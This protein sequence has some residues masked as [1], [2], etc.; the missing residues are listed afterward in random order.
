MTVYRVP[1]PARRLLLLP[2]LIL[3][4]MLAMTYLVWDH[5]RQSARQE[6]RAQF[7]FAL[8]DAVSRIAQRIAAYEQM[9][10]GVQGL[11]ATTELHN[12]QA[13][14]DYVE[15]LQLAA[16][17]SG[18]QLLGVVERVDPSARAA[19]VAAIRRLGVADYSI[20]PPGEREVYAPI[21]QRES[22][23]G[24]N[25]GPLGFDAWGN[26]VRRLAMERARDTGMAAITGKLQLA[27]DSDAEDTPGFIMYLPLYSHGQPR[28][29]VAQRRAAL[30]GWVYAAFHMR[31][32]MTSL[33]G[34]QAQSFAFAIYDDVTPSAAAL[35]YRNRDAVVGTINVN[36]SMI[37][38]GHPWTLNLVALDESATRFGRNVS[39]II[40]VT[41]AGLSLLMALLAWFMI[42]GRARALLLAAEMTEELRH[43]AQHD[44]LTGLPNRALFSDRVASQIAYAKR[45]GGRFAMIFLDLDKFKPVND[46]Y[47]HG[48]GDLLLQQV[49]KRLLDSIRASDTVGR[50][51]GDEF[52]LLIGELAGPDDALALA[53]K[54][55]QE[56]RQPYRVDGHELI[57]SCCL[58]IAIYPDDGADEITLA[59]RADAAMYRAK[60]GGRDSV[61]MAT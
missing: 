59:K 25:S 12:R 5:E 18:I 8:R 58:G 45:H 40:A 22:Y 24:R 52:V 17:F 42:N 26:P 36:Q 27:I 54:I 11:L 33:Y 56:V 10:R 15:T 16:N 20:Y 31:D 19:H 38:A 14:H 32:F 6:Q 60:D 2:W 35:M 43:M 34:R 44:S 3:V 39:L 51:G 49:A 23:V 9:L 4:A 47:G 48:V 30:V 41:G 61:R 50:I 55:R 29:S 7:D 37:V 13:I 1:L 21:M 28:D 53:E 57:V 46:N